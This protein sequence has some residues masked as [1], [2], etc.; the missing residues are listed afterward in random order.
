MGRIRTIKP[1]FFLDDE[2]AALPAVTRLLFIGLWT[3]VD[4]EGRL[5]DKPLKI[6]AQI[7]PWEKVSVDSLLEDLWRAGFIVR[8]QAAGRRYIAVPTFKRHQRV[9]HTELPSAIPA[10][11]GDLEHPG[12]SPE[13]YGEAPERHG[14]TPECSGM[15]RREGKGKEGKGKEGKG[16]EKCTQRHTEVNDRTERTTTFKRPTLEEV[17]AYLRE[18]SSR[19]DAQ[20]FHAYYESNGWRVGKNPMKSWHSAVITWERNDGGGGSRP[21]VAGKIAAAPGKYANIETTIV[22]TDEEGQ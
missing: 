13:Q 22:N 20:K 3:L 9:H 1:D 10:P 4:R 21:A 11:E 12:D 14:E 6:Q 8:Y 17:Q 15:F 2:L 7:L 18:R 16:I 19:V 5:E